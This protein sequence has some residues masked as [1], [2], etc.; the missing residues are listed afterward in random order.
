MTRN[1]HTKN[2]TKKMEVEAHTLNICQLSSVYIN[3]VA[4]QLGSTRPEDLMES[5]SRGKA[6]FIEI[7]QDHYKNRRYL[8]ESQQ[9]SQLTSVNSPPKKQV[10]RRLHASKPYQERLLNM[11]EARREIATALKLHRATMKHATEVQKFQQQQQQ[12][13]Q[14]QNPTPS[15]TLELSP[16]VLEEIQKELN[17][18]RINFKTHLFNYTFPTYLQN[19]KLLP[20]KYHAFPWMYPP[21]T[22]IP[23]HD[24]LSSN[25]PSGLDLNLQCFNNKSNSFSNNL[26]WESTIQS[27]S[28]PT[29][30]SSNSPNSSI[31]SFQASCLSKSSC[32]ASCDALDP[33]SGAFHPRM[34]PD[35]IAEIHLIGEQHDMEWNDKMNMMTSAWWSKLLSNMD[36]SFC[37]SAG[38][39]KMDSH[40]EVFNMLSCLSNG[41]AREPCLA[42]QHMWNHYNKD[43]YLPDA[44]F[45]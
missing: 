36:G 14:Q 33:A 9:E 5:K 34:E 16:A 15:P 17:E 43:Y 44:T 12:Q 26:C 7:S 18:N 38:G 10:R 42:E 45:P 24:N 28:Q 1:S 20:S 27:S 29:S 32:Q 31:P 41:D 21:T 19:T 6:S 25:H 22:T 30:S 37:E 39:E 40:D 3:H 23:V 8:S 11:A 2:I 13:Q 4:K 35:E